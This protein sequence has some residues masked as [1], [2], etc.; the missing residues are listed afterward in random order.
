MGNLSALPPLTDLFKCHTVEVVEMVS[1]EGMQDALK[2]LLDKVIYLSMAQD[3]MDVPGL[4][5]QIGNLRQDLAESRA[6]ATDLAAK[7]AR[8]C[9]QS[10]P[11]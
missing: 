7:Q 8:S 1:A 6:E 9:Y 4:Q 10:L 2:W 3:A 11:N 5:R